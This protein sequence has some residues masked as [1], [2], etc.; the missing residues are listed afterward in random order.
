M[1]GKAE[2]SLQALE[3]EESSKFTIAVTLKEPVS[4]HFTE[5]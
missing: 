5:V 2:A 3:P 1:Y 4:H